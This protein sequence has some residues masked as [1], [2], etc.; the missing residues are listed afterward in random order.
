[1]VVKVK[2]LSFT[3]IKAQDTTVELTINNGLPAFNIVGLA[4]KAI[5]ESKERIRST[6]SVLGMPLPAKR[7]TVNISPANVVKSGTHFDLPIAIAILVACGQIS[8]ESIKN[9]VFIG[10][11]SLD[12]AIRPVKGVVASAIHCVKNKETLVIAKEQESQVLWVKKTKVILAECL[13]SLIEHL[14][15]KSNLAMQNNS[16]STLQAFNTKQVEV[17]FKDIKGQETAKR[18]IQIAASGRHNILMVG[19]PGSGKSMLAKAIQG[20][21]PALKRHEVLEVNAIYSLYGQLEDNKLIIQRPFRSPHHSASSSS[22]IGGGQKIT[23][24]EV[25]FAHNG[26]LFLD[27]MAEFSKS[28]IDAL[29]QPIED[30]K[31][32][33][34]RANDSKSFP[35]NFQLVATMNPCKCGYLND[36][37]KSCNK[38][39]ACSIAYKERISGPILDRF[40]IVIEVPLLPLYDLIGKKEEVS[41]ATIAKKVTHVTKIQEER[42]AHENIEYNSQMSNNLIENYCKLENKAKEILIKAGNKFGFSS[43]SYYRLIK[44]A[45]TIADFEE[46]ETIKDKHVAEAISF[47]MHV[48]NT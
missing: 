22:I 6:L 28:V 44:L 10:E 11:I 47:K 26:I 35:A 34:T 33:I 32:F 13:P 39:P 27:E 9:T 2:T 17:D 30:K 40:D 15:G 5:L 38:S 29:R 42:F 37:D 31:V 45:Q 46:S 18:A 8:Q 20:I 14:N 7:I 41:S 16:K 43:R 23:P 12:G 3:D 24:G 19:P 25:T 48:F 36:P 4:D 1:M 21:T